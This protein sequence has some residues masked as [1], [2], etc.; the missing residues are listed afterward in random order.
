MFLDQK[1]YCLWL[2]ALERVTVLFEKELTKSKFHFSFIVVFG[3]S[4]MTVDIL[5]N[6]TASND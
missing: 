4:I 6:S 3:L 1:I 2:P 5:K